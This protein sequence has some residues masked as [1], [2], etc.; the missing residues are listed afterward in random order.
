M[1]IV[2]RRK[3]IST[4]VGNGRPCFKKAKERILGRIMDKMPEHL[5]G[6]G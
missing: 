5:T 1:Q 4:Y 2:E 6:G 3:V